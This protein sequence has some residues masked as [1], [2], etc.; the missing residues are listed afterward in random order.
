MRVRPTRVRRLRARRVRR[1]AIGTALVLSLAVLLNPAVVRGIGAVVLPSSDARLSLQGSALLEGPATP[2]TP[3]AAAFGVSSLHVTHVPEPSVGVWVTEGLDARMLG[4]LNA[5]AEGTPSAIQPGGFTLHRAVAITVAIK[6]KDRVVVTNTATVGQLLSAMGIE[7][8]GNDR[9]APS[10]RTPLSDTAR[11]A[12]DRVDLK[13]LRV[14]SSVPYEV[15]TS[16]TS[17]LPTGQIR[18][19]RAGHDGTVQRE[20]RQELVNGREVSRVLIEQRVVVEAVDELRQVG[21]GPAPPPSPAP[22]APS[23]PP[24][25]SPSPPSGQHGTQT[26]QGTWYHTPWSGLTAA[27]PWLPFGTHVT[28]TNLANGRSVTVVINDRGPFGGRIIDLSPQAFARLA[29][30]PTGVIP[31]KLVW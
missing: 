18:V 13:T 22:P 28:V 8:D 30:L 4:I 29:P 21:I 1:R 27:H 16:T 20:Y 12:F 9:V 6:G 24:P 31:V 10:P 3:V 26:G 17:D 15:V 2:L 25:P 7:P 23:P 11:V 5:P 14:T 19:V